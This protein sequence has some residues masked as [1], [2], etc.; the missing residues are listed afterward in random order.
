[1][2]LEARMRMVANDVAKKQ[3]ELEELGREQDRFDGSG[4][5]PQVTH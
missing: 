2:E 3:R 1:V 4:E 5:N